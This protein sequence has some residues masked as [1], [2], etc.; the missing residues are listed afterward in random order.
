MS[1]SFDKVT[2]DIFFTHPVSIDLLRVFP[3]MIFMD[4]TYKTNKIQ[5]DA[6]WDY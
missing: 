4:F 6:Y 5:V 3:Y 2:K 1:N